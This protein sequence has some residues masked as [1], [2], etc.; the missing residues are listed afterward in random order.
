MVKLTQKEV[1][2][3]YAFSR[4]EDID[5]SEIGEEKLIAVLTEGFTAEMGINIKSPRVVK[6]IINIKAPG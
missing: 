6:R 3:V 1:D 5:F 2:L 4:G